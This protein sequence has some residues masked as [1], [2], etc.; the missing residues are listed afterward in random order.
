L[1]IFLKNLNF[2]T[3]FSIIG[4]E[5]SSITGKNKLSPSKTTSLSVR[6]AE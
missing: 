6:R 3:D 4:E 2:P 5:I 1:G